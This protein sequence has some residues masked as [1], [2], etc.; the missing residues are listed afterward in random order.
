MS[1]IRIPI[2]PKLPG[3][4]DCTPNENRPASHMKWWNRPYI[5]TYTLEA[6][7]N[8][9]EEFKRRWMDAWPT[10]TRYDLRC[11]DGL[12]WDRSTNHGSFKTIEEAMEAA[13]ALARAR[14]RGGA[15]VSERN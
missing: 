7:G 1:R 14:N 5:Q 4:F 13:K 6:F 15:N 9:D 11:L 12:A 2:N 10:G 3:N 8:Q